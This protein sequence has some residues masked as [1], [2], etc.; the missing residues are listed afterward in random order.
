MV[1]VAEYPHFTDGDV[2]ILAPTGDAWRLNSGKLRDASPV[3]GRMLAENPAGHLTKKQIENGKTILWRF[4][5]KP[6]A[7][8]RF[9]TFEFV[10]SFFAFTPTL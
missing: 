3:F 8:T 6:C 10:V 5:L 1:N 4:I 7:D 9:A 2:H